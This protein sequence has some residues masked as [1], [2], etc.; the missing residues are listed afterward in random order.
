MGMIAGHIAPGG[1]FLFIDHFAG[2]DG[3]VIFWG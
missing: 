1:V 2:M 3:N